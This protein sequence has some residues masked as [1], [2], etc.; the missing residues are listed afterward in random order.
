MV[1]K[2]IKP[3]L[4]VVLSAAM[5][6]PCYWINKAYADDRS[7]VLVCQQEEH[8]HTDECFSRVLVCGKEE[9]ELH[10][11]DDSCYTETTKYVCGLDEAPADAGHAHSEAC[12][13]ASGAL[14]C[15]QEERPATDGHTHSDSCKEAT[16]TLIC[17]KGDVHKHSDACYGRGEELL[18]QKVEH[19]H[20]DGCYSNR[21]AGVEREEDWEKEY[22]DFESS[23]VWG[24]D[25][26][27]AAEKY[28]GLRENPYNFIIDKNGNH[29]GY[30][31]FADWYNRYKYENKTVEWFDIRSCDAWCASF[32]S[33]C[34]Y[35]IGI[36]EDFFPYHNA[37]QHWINQL[38][39][40][41]LYEES[42]G[43]YT[44][45]VGDLIFFD[46]DGNKRSDHVG[47]VKEVDQETGK[48][49]T[50]EGNVKNDCEIRKYNLVYNG[51]MGYG[52]VT[53][54]QR[55]FQVWKVIHEKLF[56]QEAVESGS[57]LPV[58]AFPADG[59]HAQEKPNISVS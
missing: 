47:I 6:M 20:G 19:V 33:F 5:L 18:C 16:R 28:V 2:M 39:E 34:M 38:T 37:C 25:L 45:R 1:K 29:Q 32:I 22:K 31:K 42:K 53:R 3:A 10:E 41:G 48:V 54:A 9:S 43:E 21:N 27:A 24:M 56:P 46:F 12:Y 4:S 59:F 11:H 15:G 14:I 30:T 58:L 7:H 17:A 55:N 52:T 36:P 40:L 49:T 57:D 50:I 51:I 44:P 13:D 8:V 26:V 23:G 35:H